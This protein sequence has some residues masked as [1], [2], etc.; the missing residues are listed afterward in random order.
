MA[1]LGTCVS[2]SAAAAPKVLTVVV[3]P[4]G[5]FVVAAAVYRIATELGEIVDEFV[6]TNGEGGY[7]CA[8]L[9]EPYYGLELAKEEVGQ[10]ELLPAGRILGV[11]QHNFLDETAINNTADPNDVLG[12]TWDSENVIASLRELV[13]KEQHQF[14]ISALPWPDICGHRSAATILTVQAVSKLEREFRTSPIRS[15][16]DDYRD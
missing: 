3:H 1:V 15:S 16:C 9:A 10:R 11:R 5:D 7:R 2:V 14:V 4:D 8:T 6:I 12:G 13:V